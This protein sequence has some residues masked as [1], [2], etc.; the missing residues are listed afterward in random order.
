[1][2]DAA[3]HRSLGV[4]RWRGVTVPQGLGLL[5]GLVLPLASALLYHPYALAMASRSLEATRQLGLPYVAGEIAVILYAGRRGFTLA[6]VLREAPRWARWALALFVATFWI[7]SLAVSARP[8]FSLSLALIWLVHLQAGAAVFHLA[9]QE[10]IGARPVAAGLVLGLTALGPIT[11]FHLTFAPPGEGVETWLFG[12]PIPGFISVRLF[13]AWCGV[14]AVL[15]LGLI[16]RAEREAGPTAWLYPALGWSAGLVAWTG[17][18]AALLAAAVALLA[19]MALCRH[20]GSGRFWWR[21]LTAVIAGSVLVPLAMPIISGGLWLRPGGMASADVFASGRLE[22]WADT[23]AIAIDRPLLG[24]G[25]A[26]N[27]WLVSLRGVHHVQ[28]HNALVQFFMNWGL[29]PT[30]PALA[31][32]GA[33]AW[34]AHR[35]ARGRPA[36]LPMVMAVDYLLVAGMFDGMLHFS[37]FVMLLMVLLGACLAAGGTAEGLAPI[38]AS[39]LTGPASRASS[40]SLRASP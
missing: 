40:A 3:L 38:A 22:L 39:A 5:I 36:L 28:P 20:P 21:S 19:A 8:S 29:L 27:A 24:H 33:A 26:A 17:T 12:A 15:V 23:L 2:L 13:G 30:V 1:M 16:W 4:R 37:E 35:A 10:G 7:S 14:T 6:A 9:R 34:H 18:R 25:M 32:L 11:A 31:L